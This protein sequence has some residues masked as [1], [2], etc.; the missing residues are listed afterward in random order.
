MF[1]AALP[2]RYGLHFSVGDQ[3]VGFATADTEEFWNVFG[4]EP[5][6]ACGGLHFGEMKPD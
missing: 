4:P 3:F 6:G 1:L 2:E 5:F